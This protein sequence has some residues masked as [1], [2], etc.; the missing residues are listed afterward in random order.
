MVV[1]PTSLTPANGAVITAPSRASAVYSEPYGWAGHMYFWLLDGAG[2]TLKEG[3]DDAT[4][5]GRTTSN[6]GTATFALPTLGVGTYSVYAMAYD[7][8]LSP[9]VGPNTFKVAAAPGA[10]TGLQ[11][12]EGAV[13]ALVSWT[14]P[15]TNGAPLTSIN[16]VATDTGDGAVLQTSCSDTCLSSN[17]T[18]FPGLTPGRSYR[19]TASA[20]NAVGTGPVSAPPTDP[21]TVLAASVLTPTNVAATKGDTQATVSWTPPLVNVPVI[22]TYTVTAYRSSDSA[23][24]GTANT[25][26][27]NAVVTGLRNGVLAR[28]A[29]FGSPNSITSSNRR[30]T[31]VS[32][33]EA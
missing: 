16:L 22:T 12:I 10:P 19:F 6:G 18:L 13:S 11:A 27:S 9:Q 23:V 25:A 1:A 7:G 21:I 17:S 20:T 26:Q 4:M 8:A 3:W 31:A 2:K 24:V 32:N 30:H 28:A 33:S 14:A 15:P 29:S 5:A